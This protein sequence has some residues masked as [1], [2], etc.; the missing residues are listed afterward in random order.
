VKKQVLNIVSDAGE[1]R[2]KFCFM[3]PNH[4]IKNLSFIIDTTVPDIETSIILIP[5]FF[6]YSLL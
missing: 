4:L 5:E 3:I 1:L 6:F 2:W